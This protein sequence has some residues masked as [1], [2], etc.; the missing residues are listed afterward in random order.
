MKV[1][2]NNQNSNPNTLNA[3]NYYVSN[4]NEQK[5]HNSFSLEKWKDCLFHSAAPNDNMLRTISIGYVT[6]PVSQAS[7]SKHDF[8][9]KSVAITSHSHPSFLL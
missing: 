8:A 6:D 5:N 9:K 4:K 7:G 3:D 2:K 1:V